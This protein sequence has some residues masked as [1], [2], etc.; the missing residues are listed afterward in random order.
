MKQRAQLLASSLFISV[1]LTSLAYGQN[2]PPVTSTDASNRE[3]E[4]IVV[5]AERR[6]AS[7]QD[8]ALTVAAISGS[9]LKNAGVTDTLSLVKAMPGLSVTTQ[10]NNGYLYLRGLGTAIVGIG[11]DAS[12][13][14][15]IDGAY[16]AR[17][18]DILM[19]FIDVERVELLKGPQGTLYGRNAAAGAMNVIS[20]DPKADTSGYV[21]ASVGNYGMGSGTAVFNTPLIED[22]LLL[23]AAIKVKSRDGYGT[24]TDANGTTAETESLD[25]LQFRV[26][27][28]ALV[29]ETLRLDFGLEHANMDYGLSALPE[30]KSDCSKVRGDFSRGAN[31]SNL[32]N[33]QQYSCNVASEYLGGNSTRDRAAMRQNTTDVDG[34]PFENTTVNWSATS[35]AV[36]SPTETTELSLLFNYLNGDGRS[37]ADRDGTDI[38]YAY[39]ASRTK[40]DSYYAE[41]VLNSEVFGGRLKYTLGSTYFLED[42]EDY[43]DVLSG[44]VNSRVKLCHVAG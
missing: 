8:V 22:K 41:L 26:K 23:R 24:A 33:T 31:L 28:R 42:L 11:A 18:R 17:P 1:G 16:R 27:L 6:S 44:I 21:E 35:R 19:E 14:T 29:S 9:A 4:T 43:V 13:A 38:Q 12:V 37:G 15:Y 25:A 7:T 10:G 39:T 36:W 2:A 30:T 40:T 34:K 3:I 32:V 20:V 5:T